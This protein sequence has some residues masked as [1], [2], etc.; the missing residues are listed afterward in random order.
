VLRE[1]LYIKGEWNH[2]QPFQ[3][4]FADPLGRQVRNKLLPHYLANKKGNCVS[5]PLLFIAL[6]QKLS[7]DVTAAQAPSHVFVKYRDE[8]GNWLNLETTGTAKP[9]S[10]A[11]YREQSPMTD[12]AIASGL[13]MRPLGKKETILV[14]LDTLL[15]HYREQQRHGGVVDLANVML[16]HYPNWVPA[17]LSRGSA[18]ALVLDILEARYGSEAAIPPAEW[19]RCTAFKHGHFEDFA[20]AEALGW[21]MPS[22]E[23]EDRYQQTIQQHLQA[24]H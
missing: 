1:Y 18:F 9:T 10:E 24:N 14:M 8:A 3:Y 6:G 17:L 4:D 21:R 13:Y 15:Q 5:M 11:T 16:E 2:H 12:Q 20:R 7:I 22:R 23:D 19:E